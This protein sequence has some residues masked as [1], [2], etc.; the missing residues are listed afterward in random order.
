[1]GGRGKNS[2]SGGG[3]GGGGAAGGGGYDTFGSKDREL[4]D[5]KT[6]KELQKYLD[7]GG[8]NIKLG[9][10]TRAVDVNVLKASIQGMTE[11]MDAHPFMK[12]TPIELKTS[13]AR[14]YAAQASWRGIPPTFDVTLGG[15]M[16]NGTLDSISSRMN[17]G[18]FHPANQTAASIIAHET[19]H[20]W[21]MFK[22]RQQY[23]DTYA[24][25]NAVKYNEIS[26]NLVNKAAQ[27]LGVSET[28]RKAM[29]NLIKSVSGYA[30]SNRAETL[31]ECVADVYAN[32]D[33]ASQLSKEV[34]R[35]MSE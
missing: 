34:W 8:Y 33:K 31:A 9:R 3:G 22:A 25:F 13:T 26:T 24:A 17:N 29:R 14:S 23:G 18:D 1:M 15:L 19:G 2:G 12:D 4:V 35:L 6:H 5:V 32:G 11:V 28:D 21:E 7:D 20:L 16:K 30:T 10:G 27:N